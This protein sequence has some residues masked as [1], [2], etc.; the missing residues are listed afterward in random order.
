MDPPLSERTPLLLCLGFKETRST[1]P[2]DEPSVDYF[3]HREEATE[4]A[5]GRGAK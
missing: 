3:D 5:A 2:S 4:G 1:G